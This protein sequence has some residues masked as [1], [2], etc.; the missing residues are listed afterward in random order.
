MS[1][2]YDHE[3][4]AKA[5][6]LLHATLEARKKKAR[7]E[8]KPPKIPKSSVCFC[9]RVYPTKTIPLTPLTKTSK[10]SYTFTLYI[11]LSLFYSISF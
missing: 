2:L 5:I 7:S 6:K 11:L 4:E 10:P 1:T 3:Y 8:S 9:I